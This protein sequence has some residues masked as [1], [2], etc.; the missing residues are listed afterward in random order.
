MYVF[1]I[2]LYVLLRRREFPEDFQQEM[3]DLIMS[4]FVRVLDPE[5]CGLPK[6]LGRPS[7]LALSPHSALHSSQHSVQCQLRESKMHF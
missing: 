4:R 7:I 3:Y 5:K 2:Y 1:I 6:V